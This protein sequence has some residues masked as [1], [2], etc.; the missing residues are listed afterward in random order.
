MTR[1]GPPGVAAE[2]TDLAWQRTGLGI[3][4]V[5]GLI[6][7]R[8]VDSDRPALLV[9]AGVTALFGLGVLGGLAPARA[10]FVQRRR[11][12]DGDVAARR[13]VAAVTA[14]VIAICLAAA[15]AVTVPV[16]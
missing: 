11:L 16:D 9:A 12:E 13:S 4:A 6:G 8:A 15:V 2:R 10:R 5:A 14:A 1:A 3:L 7:H